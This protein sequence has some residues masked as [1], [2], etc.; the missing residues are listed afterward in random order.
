MAAIY[1]AFSTYDSPPRLSFADTPLDPWPWGAFI[2]VRT[3][4]T[5]PFKLD[6]TAIPDWTKIELLNYSTPV[7]TVTPGP[8][9]AATLRLEAPIPAPGVYG[10]SALV[11]HAD[12]VTV[13]TTNV[14]AFTTV[15][16]PGGAAII[17]AAIM[18]FPKIRRSAPSS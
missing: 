4:S 9:P 3:P 16:E 7:L 12:G 17:L 5:L 6:L 14:L 10:F 15:P 11:T 18:I 8:S 1:R 2:G 13:S